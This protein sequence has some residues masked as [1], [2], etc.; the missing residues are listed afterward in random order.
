VLVA[1]SEAT[2]VNDTFSHRGAAL[3]P[4]EHAQG[5]D[6]DAAFGQELRDSGGQT[7][8]M[9]PAHGVGDEVVREALAAVNASEI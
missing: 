8:T 4:I 9:M 3:H 1:C 7:D 6:V 5:I 2:P